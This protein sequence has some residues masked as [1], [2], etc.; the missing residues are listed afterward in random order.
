M[1]RAPRGCRKRSQP[2]SPKRRE[3][4]SSARRRLRRAEIF[5]SFSFVKESRLRADAADA[6]LRAAIRKRV[7]GGACKFMLNRVKIIFVPPQCQPKFSS[8]AHRRAQKPTL[9]RRAAAKRRRGKRRAFASCVPLLFERSEMARNAQAGAQSLC[10]DETDSP[11]PAFAQCVRFFNFY[12]V[13]LRLAWRPTSKCQRRRRLWRRPLREPALPC[14]AV[15][16]RVL[17][18]AER[19]ADR[20]C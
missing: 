4:K 13:R 15:Q 6:Q 18:R 3:S 1:L 7:F 16:R 11:S 10:G 8:R 5:S 12:A 19:S 20:A 9:S 17:R 14:V 2:R